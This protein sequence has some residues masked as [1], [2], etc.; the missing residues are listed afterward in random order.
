M[1]KTYSKKDIK[2]FLATHRFAEEFI[3]KKSL[4]VEEND[5]LFV[6]KKPFFR[7][8]EDKWVPSLELLQEKRFILP[9]VVVD[10]GTPPF[11]AKGAD[12]MRPGIV[13]CEEFPKDAVV[14][15]VDEV[16][17]F[18]IATGRAMLSSE[19]II[20]AKEGKVIKIIFNLQS[21]F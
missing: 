4:V 21:K 14:V 13:S 7:R 8:F 12:L 9:K 10:K 5:I 19:D 17:D 1:R 15:I 20:N 18:P 6:D 2:Q 11:I 3:N 16:H